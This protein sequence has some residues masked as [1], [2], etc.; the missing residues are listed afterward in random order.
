MST[1]EIRILYPPQAS[2]VWSWAKLPIDVKAPTE[3]L[4]PDINMCDVEG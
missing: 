1:P 2:E 3:G 4:L